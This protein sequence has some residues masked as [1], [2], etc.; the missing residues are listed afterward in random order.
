MTGFQERR[1]AGRVAM[2]EPIAGR[3]RPTLEVRLLDLSATGARIAHREQLH[4]GVTLALQL[5]PAL[6]L[7]ALSVRVIHSRVVGTEPGPAGA[8]ILRYESGMVFL[9]L[10]EE[11]RTVLHSLIAQLVPN[12]KDPAQTPPC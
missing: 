8:Q 12:G 4:P 7:R 1:G 11:Q 9:G 10:T 5:P 3:A 6:S 2:R